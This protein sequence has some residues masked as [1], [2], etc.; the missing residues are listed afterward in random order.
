MNRTKIKN[1]APQAR[2]DFL[3]AVT[4]RA[5]FYG[6]TADQDRAGHGQ[7][8]RGDH[9][10][11][12]LPQGGRREAEGARGAGQAG[13]LRGRRWRRW[14]TRGSTGWSPSATWSCTAT[15]THGYRVLSHPDAAKPTP[16]ILEQAEHVELPGLNRERVDR[17]EARRDE[18][19]RALPAAADRPVQRPAL[20]HAVPVRAD[21]RRD[22]TGPARQP[23][24][25]RLD[26][27][28]SSSPRSTRRT[29]RRSRSS[30]G[31]T[32]SYISEQYE[33]VIGKVV[34]SADIPAA[35]QLF[36]PKW[37]VQLPRP[38][39]ARAALAGDLPAVAARGSR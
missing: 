31:S 1:Y 5:A 10:R 37:I 29:G 35:T 34:A 30:A 33:A 36:T 23:A 25:L 21:R 2:R 8:R 14:P 28:A 12:G 7:G 18:G 6:L 17:T 3:Q 26:R 4:D 9:R 13:R 38:E 20:G 15:S 27:S 39:H 24:A 16:E 11:A 32:S 22:G 19:G